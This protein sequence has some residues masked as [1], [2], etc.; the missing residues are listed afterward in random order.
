MK[1]RS[2]PVKVNTAIKNDI[3]LKSR[4][5]EDLKNNVPKFL[6]SKYTNTNTQIYKFTNIQIHKYTN[7]QIQFGSN[8]QIDLTCDIFFKMQ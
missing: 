3:F 2:V 7:T 1:L 8:Y 4:W 6:T 5:Y